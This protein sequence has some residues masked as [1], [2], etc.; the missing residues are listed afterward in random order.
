M[1]SGKF[2]LLSIS[3]LCL[4]CLMIPV[5]IAIILGQMFFIIPAL[6]IIMYFIYA[7]KMLKEE[8]YLCKKDK[9]LGADE[10]TLEFCGY[11][12]ND[13]FY[14]M[15]NGKLFGTTMRFKEKDDYLILSG[16][17]PKF[18]LE[19]GQSYKVLFFRNRKAII[20]IHKLS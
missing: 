7:V 11:I 20:Q 10:S 5:I 19:I 18:R 6:L 1:Y 3:S 17:F 14:S 15:K 12:K 8:Y 9:E 16:K 4:V 13:T 2:I